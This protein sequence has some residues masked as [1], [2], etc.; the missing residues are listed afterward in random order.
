M[1]THARECSRSSNAVHTPWPPASS[2]WGLGARL[3]NEQFSDP[4]VRAQRDKLA[5]L[6]GMFVAADGDSTAL[7]YDV[8][9]HEDRWRIINISFDGVSGTDIQRAGFE[10]FLREGA[11]AR[12]RDKLDALIRTMEQ[13]NN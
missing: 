7:T 12:L 9:R 11:A 13:D 10:V 4:V 6:S 5:R 2:L 8:R 1:A 3:D